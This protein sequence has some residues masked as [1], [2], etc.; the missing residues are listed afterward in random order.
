MLSDELLPL[1]TEERRP[2]GGNLRYSRLVYLYSV[3][4]HSVLSAGSSYFGQ[5]FLLALGLD[6]PNSLYQSTV[7]SVLSDLS[8]EVVDASLVVPVLLD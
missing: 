8:L 4:S 3:E 7:L 2:P 1:P 5:S 6:P